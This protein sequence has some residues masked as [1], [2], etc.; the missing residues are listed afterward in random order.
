MVQKPTLKGRLLALAI[1]CVV[2]IGVSEAILRFAFPNWREFSSARFITTELVAGSRAVFVG[3]AG[4]DG[5]FAQNN[6]DF[7]VRLSINEFGLRDPAPAQD[8]DGRLWVVG[9]SM[10]FGWGVEREEM[11]S[12]RLAQL[13]GIPTYSVASPG[14]DVCGYQMLVERMP[15]NIH[16]RAVLLGLVLE[17]D[18]REYDCRADVAVAETPHAGWAPTALNL[19]EIKSFLTDQSATYNFFAVTLKRVGFLTPILKATGLVAQEHAR[20]VG[21]DPMRF[22]AV[23]A[24][25]ADEIARLRAAFPPS[26]PF[27]VLVMP[28]R[29]EIRDDDPFFRRTREAVIE[30][31]ATR[32]IETIDPFAALRAAGFAPTHFRH[33]GHWSALGH[34]IAAK[35]A[36]PWARRAVG[37]VTEQ[38]NQ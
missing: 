8:A 17:N 19:P 37:T 7:R 16:P 38:R 9:D 2:L 30:A 21:V 25:S 5:Y 22:G 18:L 27:A 31:L 35:A 34:E 26:V 32:H 11:Y 4:F 12:T 24:S 28:V 3:R 14:A 20:I 6:G 1:G 29:L 15:K 36:T 33:D 10:T 23:I 13:S